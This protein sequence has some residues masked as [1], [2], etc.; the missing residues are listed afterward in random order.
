[1]HESWRRKSAA[2]LRET[3]TKFM[4][5][6]RIEIAAKERDDVAHEIARK[7]LKRNA[8]E[9]TKKKPRGEQTLTQ[10]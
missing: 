6:I 2:K 5:A 1:M 3:G 9:N 7:K 8:E 4:V 10:L